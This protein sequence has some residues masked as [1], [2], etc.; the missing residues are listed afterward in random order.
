MYTVAVTRINMV[1]QLMRTLYKIPLYVF[2]CV[3]WGDIGQPQPRSDDSPHIN[4]F[5]NVDTNIKF[6]L[7]IIITIGHK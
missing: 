4:Q 2:E 7:S 1:S 5:L 3:L 6:N